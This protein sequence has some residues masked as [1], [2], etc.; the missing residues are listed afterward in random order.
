MKNNKLLLFAGSLLVPM[1][2]MAGPRSFQQAKAIA[3]KQAAKIGVAIDEQAAAKAR[4]QASGE[5]LSL[6]SECYYV[7]PNAQGRGFTIVSGDDRMPE[8]VAYADKGSYDE[9]QLSQGFVNLMKQYQ[10]FCTR[11][12]LGDATALKNLAEAKA[13]H[14]KMAKQSAATKAAAVAPLLGNIE[15]DQGAPYNNMCPKYDD[16]H[17][18]A[19]GCVA[20]AMAQVM[21]Y[22]KYPKQLKTDIPGYASHWNTITTTI[23]A[24]TKEEGIYD[25]D[26]MLPKYSVATD[27]TDTQKDAVAKLMYHCG[28]SVKMNYGPES[29]ASVSA[30]HLA[31]YFGYD[32]DLMM[33]VRRAS[34]SLD[35]WMQLIDT[36][37]AAKRPILYDGQSS[38]GGH[39]FICDGS[40]GDGLYHINWGWDGNQNGY[41]DL[42]ILNPEKGGTGS[43]NAAD[44]YN[45]SCSMTI[46]IAPDNGVVDAP[47]AQ[48]PSVSVYRTGAV[49]ITKGIRQKTS[50]K[51]DFNLQVTFV[52]QDKKAFNGY[53]GLGILQK[54]G[55]YK[56]IS[57][58][59]STSL[60]GMKDDGMMSSKDAR[61]SVSEA[62]EVGKTPVFAIYSTNGTTW[63][64]VDYMNSKIPVVVK[65]TERELTL[66]SALN[67]Q[68]QLLSG[69]LETGAYCPFQVTLSNDCDFEYQGIVNVLFDAAAEKP[70][71]L[72]TDLFVTV[73]AHGSITRSF[74]LIPKEAG[75]LY[76]WLDDEPAGVNLVD[77]QKFAVEQGYVPTIYLVEATT[78]ASSDLYETEQAYYSGIKMR[79]PKVNDDKAEFTYKIQNDGEDTSIGIAFAAA[80]GEDIPPTFH[81][82]YN[83]EWVQ[84]PGNGEVTTITRTVTP[85]QMGSH[86]ICGDLY[87]VDA[88]YHLTSLPT[89][90]PSYILYGVDGTRYQMPGSQKLVYVSGLPAGISQVEMDASGVSGVSGFWDVYNLNGQKVARISAGSAGSTGSTGS[91]VS[92]YSAELQRLGLPAGIYIVNH[93]KIFVK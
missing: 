40:D 45:R 69:K 33:D 30:S 50:D 56:L 62:F 2:A 91:T 60:Y 46:G 89:Y 14:S 55:S 93:Q 17:A 86:S 31:K 32:E 87:A 85:E 13:W 35:Q 11:V 22:Y 92:A 70:N 1:M 88:N 3:E 76:L 21:A 26:N 27:V 80:S 9:T 63:Q 44:G 54:D 71:S 18:S 43:G 49:N 34:F 73:P 6:N 58:K 47:L 75:H 16:V 37:L 52:N 5:N 65:A 48:I 28:V 59:I 83:V 66:A 12:E 19:T 67:A 7:F 90:L 24:V 84:L 74:R 41:F 64:K 78:N 36:E 72:A 10:E 51:F 23:P 20:T 39:Q 4:K 77:A 57:N 42:A 81:L 29:S 25:W 15:W 79:A 53:L 38:D 8:I 82:P 68:V 61:L